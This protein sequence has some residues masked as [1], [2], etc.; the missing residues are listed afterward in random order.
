M[1]PRGFKHNSKG[2]KVVGSKVSK[3]GHG[4]HL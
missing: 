2:G 4:L 1:V 3:S